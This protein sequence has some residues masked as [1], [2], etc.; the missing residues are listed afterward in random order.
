MEAPGWHK[1]LML[2]IILVGLFL[3]EMPITTLFLLPLFFWSAFV[4]RW[5]WTP[6]RQQVGAFVKN[7]AVLR[8]PVLAFVVWVLVVMPPLTL[9]LW[10]FR[11][12]YLGDT[13]LA[14]GHARTAP[15]L[16]VAV[17]RG[18]DLDVLLGNL[19][20]LFGL[21]LVPWS[22]QPV[23]LHGERHLA[24]RPGDEPAEDRDPGGSSSRLRSSWPSRAGGRSRCTC[25]A[26]WWRCRSSSCSSAC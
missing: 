8:V 22:A 11:F 19:A 17:T 5:P 25:A 16:G 6:P 7:G 4:P 14:G 21:S 26:C 13:L 18:L 9:Y 23:H 15:S 20:T 12:D 10:G 24:V 2:A 3:D 1:Y